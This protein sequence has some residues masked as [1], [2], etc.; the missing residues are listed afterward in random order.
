M[1]AECE[2][3]WDEVL[4]QELTCLHVERNV[5]QK[6]DLRETPYVNG[7]RHGVATYRRPYGEMVSETP[8]VNGR[9]HGNEIEHFENEQ[10]ITGRFVTTYADGERQL[11]VTILGAR[12]P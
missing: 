5:H 6:G 3:D 9:R 2:V 12:P 7:R 4:T 10:G 8:W 11:E 1:L